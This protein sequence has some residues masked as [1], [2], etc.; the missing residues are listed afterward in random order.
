MKV[1]FDTAKIPG[2]ENLT[3]EQKQAIAGY[4]LDV[5]EPDMSGY[6]KKDVFDKKAA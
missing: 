4:E 3:E 2:F 5:P 6:V 1:K